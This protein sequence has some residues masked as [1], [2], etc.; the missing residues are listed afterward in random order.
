ME[1]MDTYEGLI[2]K[3]DQNISNGIFN[4]GGEDQ[5]SYFKYTEPFAN[6]F[7]LGHMVDNNKNLRHASPSLEETWAT[8]RWA[9]RGFSPF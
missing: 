8:L 2:V 6:H 5:I 3:D 4:V 9:V 7:Y 1:I